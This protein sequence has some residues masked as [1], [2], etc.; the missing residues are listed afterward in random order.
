MQYIKFGFLGK[1]FSGASE[2]PV[3]NIT[4]YLTFKYNPLYFKGMLL[5]FKQSE[6]IN[7]FQPDALYWETYPI[8]FGLYSLR[9]N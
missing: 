2:L 4:E 8:Y 1:R 5:T 3:N 7:T 9:W 6:I